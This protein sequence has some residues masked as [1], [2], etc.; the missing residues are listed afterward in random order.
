MDE[1]V[2][3]KFEMLYEKFAQKERKKENKKS[4]MKRSFIPSSLVLD[5]V[6]K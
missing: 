5:S 6:W 1:I 2:A 3:L 4:E